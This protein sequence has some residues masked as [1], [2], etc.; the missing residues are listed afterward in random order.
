MKSILVESEKLELIERI[1]KLTKD[2]MPFWGTMSVSQMLA[3]CTVSLQ[4]AFGEIIPELNE[5][6]LQIGRQ[7]KDRLFESE[8]F[9]KNVPTTKEFLVADNKDFENNKFILIEYINKYSLT[10]IN[11]TKMAPHPYFGDMTVK[12]W[13]MLI[14]KHTN[15]HLSQ[16]GV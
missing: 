13:G 8:M 15:H 9:T 2:T 10:D 1:N 6:F 7:V 12:E 14:W 5:K 11:D 3:H 16:F 4:L